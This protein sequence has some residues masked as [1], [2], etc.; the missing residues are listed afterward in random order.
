MLPSLIAQ[1]LR[2]LF[3][4][5]SR[6]LPV[7]ATDFSPVPTKV[8]KDLEWK[9]ASLQRFFKT[10]TI[11]HSWFKTDK[12]QNGEFYASAVHEREFK[13]DQENILKWF[14]KLDLYPMALFKLAARMQASFWSKWTEKRSKGRG[15]GFVKASRHVSGRSR[16]IRTQCTALCSQAQVHWVRKSRRF[17]PHIA[18]LLLCCC[19]GSCISKLNWT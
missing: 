18:Q 14:N 16:T 9:Y 1:H 12:A 6:A 5:I 15:N 4:Q 2:D 13:V 10:L 17:H 8:I 19:L 7:W 3:L 11:K